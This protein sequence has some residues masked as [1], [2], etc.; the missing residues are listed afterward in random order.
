MLKVLK[1]YLQ[2]KARDLEKVFMDLRLF[3]G[4]KS[5]VPMVLKSCWLTKDYMLSTILLK[6]F[7]KPLYITILI[8]IVFIFSTTK[9]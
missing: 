1:A 8:Q 2:A 4:Y 5:D 6:L 3:G 7:S 9:S